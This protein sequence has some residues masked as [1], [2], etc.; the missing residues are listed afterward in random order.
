MLSVTSF[1]DVFQRPL[2]LA[3]RHGLEVHQ[4]QPL[5]QG[6]AERLVQRHAGHFAEGDAGDGDFDWG[7]ALGLRLKAANKCA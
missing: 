1:R 7:A 3:F 5:R 6:A 2:L 4:K